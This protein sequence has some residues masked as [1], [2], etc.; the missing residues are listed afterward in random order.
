MSLS[1]GTRNLKFMQRAAARN[2]LTSPAA[3]PAPSA[4]TPQAAAQAGVA[5]GSASPTRGSNPFGV[6][7]GVQDDGLSTLSASTSR[8]VPTVDSD[9]APLS[10]EEKEAMWVLPARP[11]RSAR[12]AGHQAQAGPSS[13]RRF[14]FEQ[15]Y[16]PF[17]TTADSADSPEEDVVIKQEQAIAAEAGMSTKSRP[18]QSSST[19][20]THTSTSA[21]GGRMAFGNFGQEKKDAEM[22]AG[23][24]YGSDDEERGDRRSGGRAGY[25]QAQ[26]ARG[27]KRSSDTQRNG[28]EDDREESRLAK[29]RKMAQDRHRQQAPQPVCASALVCIGSIHIYGARSCLDSEGM[30]QSG[31]IQVIILTVFSHRMH[32]QADSCGPATT[33][34]PSPPGQLKQIPSRKYQHPIN[35]ATSPHPDLNTLPLP[36]QLLVM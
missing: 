12:P 5:S 26:G 10:K 29:I 3:S 23:D 2:A 11:A 27:K 34:P 16:M 32:P 13:G 36:L 8:S 7:S 19:P 4:G 35:F 28:Y 33:I 31:D 20:S 24:A 18:A 14:V 25:M 6:L 21:G 30:W 1:T 15:S 17:M 9:G 22:A